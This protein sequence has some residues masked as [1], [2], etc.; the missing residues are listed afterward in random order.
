MC[1]TCF[2]KLYR[3]TEK[4]IKVI[5]KKIV[6]GI[7]FQEQQGKHLKQK[8]IVD[9]ELRA[10]MYA[11][12]VSIPHRKS[13]YASE[14]TQ[15]LFFENPDLTIKKLY[16]LFRVFY[17]EKKGVAL[18]LRLKHYYKLF[19]RM[20]FS[21]SSVKTDKCDFC[22]QTKI[23]LSRNPTNQRLRTQKLLHERKYQPHKA[24]KNELLKNIPNDTLIPEF[25]YSQNL[26][27]PKLAVNKQFYKRLL[28]LNNLNIHCH[29]DGSSYFFTFLES[30]AKKDANSIVSYLHHVLEKKGVLQNDTTV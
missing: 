4:R 12:L 19:Q 17:R 30:E 15:R 11:H 20:N 9:D 6:E 27:L 21:I 1:R 14:H 3:L 8:R 7:G 23:Q 16:M 13:H 22:E 26:A 5:Q 10:L 24:L 18:L 29:N 2:S 28:W 25:D